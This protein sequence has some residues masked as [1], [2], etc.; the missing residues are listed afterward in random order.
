MS[1]QMGFA[2]ALVLASGAASAEWTRISS[3]KTTVAYVDTS[4]I[5]KAG[6]TTKSWALMDHKVPQLFI[7]QQ[8]FLSIKYQSEF[9]C[10]EDKERTLFFAMYDGNMG[11][12]EVL[13]SGAP[14]DT[15]WMPVPPGTINWDTL[16][17]VC[18]R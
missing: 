15:R 1:K 4:T 5:R 6:K 3:S 13:W 9:D 18:K 7:D 10:E 17:V 11:A 8:R 14:P 12:G 2:L 16:K